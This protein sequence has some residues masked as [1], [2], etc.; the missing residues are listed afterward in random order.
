MA[1]CQRCGMPRVLGLLDSLR[2]SMIHNGATPEEAAV[3]IHK[4]Q[5][6]GSASE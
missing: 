2:A 6:I 1:K 4:L 3:Q 5:A